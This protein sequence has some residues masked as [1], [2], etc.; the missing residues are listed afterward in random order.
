LDE[1]LPDAAGMADFRIMQSFTITPGK[2][3]CK[4]KLIV[5]PPMTLNTKLLNSEP[6][7][8]AFFAGGNGK[9]N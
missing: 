5:L 9:R 4:G 3:F 8:P 7:F 1:I 6:I 2:P